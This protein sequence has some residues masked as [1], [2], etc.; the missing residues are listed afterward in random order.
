MGKDSCKFPQCCTQLTLC[1]GTAQHR[2]QPCPTRC[3]CCTADNQPFLANTHPNTW[4][5]KGKKLLGQ[6]IEQDSLPVNNT[7]WSCLSTENLS[8][9]KLWKT[10]HFSTEENY[11]KKS[12]FSVPYKAFVICSFPDSWTRDFE[13]PKY[14]KVDSFFQLREIYENAFQN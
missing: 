9:E 6:R 10:S 7:I 13:E 12:H 8:W 1:S 14:R 3:C 4:D 5:S 11:G 2:T